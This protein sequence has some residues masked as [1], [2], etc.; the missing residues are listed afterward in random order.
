MHC[1]VGTGYLWYRRC[2]WF[3]RAYYEHIRYIP[4]KQIKHNMR[5]FRAVKD[6]FHI[7]SWIYML[8]SSIY[9]ARRSWKK[10]RRP[11]WCPPHIYICR[12]AM[13]L[14]LTQ[15]GCK[16]P[17][18]KYRN[19]RVVQRCV[20]LSKRKAASASQSV[21]AACVWW[22]AFFSGQDSA[23]LFIYNTRMFFEQIWTPVWYWKSHLLSATLGPNATLAFKAFLE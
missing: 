14:S 6:V 4:H 19:C 17:K 11:S 16:V 21:S 13:C 7:T 1:V 9:V 3:N 23:W 15:P 2:V 10:T 20:A 5:S 18:Q 12:I 22:L 8:S